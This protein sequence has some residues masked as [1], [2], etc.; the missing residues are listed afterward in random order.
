M[1][2]SAP[3]AAHSPLFQWFEFSAFK[4]EAAVQE[5]RMVKGCEINYIR[6]DF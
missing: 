1:S 3:A 5:A 2:T 6:S 4:A